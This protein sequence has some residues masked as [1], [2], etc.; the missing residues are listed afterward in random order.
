MRIYVS[1]IA[2]MRLQ[3]FLLVHMLA[4][5][6]FCSLVPPYVRKAPFENAEGTGQITIRI[7]TIAPIGLRSHAMRVYFARLDP[8]RQTPDRVSLQGAEFLPSTYLSNRHVYL[9]DAKPGEY[10]AVAAC[11]L[12]GLWHINFSDRRKIE[13]AV[14]LMRIPYVYETPGTRTIFNDSVISATRV[15]V[16]AGARVYAG[17]FD[18]RQSAQGHLAGPNQRYAAVFLAPSVYR[19]EPS[20]LAPR[21]NAY[22]GELERR[23]DT[24]ESRAEFSKA[25]AEIPEKTVK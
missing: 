24:E 15:K 17:E 23:V 5:S 20:V 9:L 2:S 13:A 16:E 8:E 21:V 4:F 7:N 19:F 22:L 11:G 18:I 12:P 14:A 25:E 1:A 6:S 3:R 10:V